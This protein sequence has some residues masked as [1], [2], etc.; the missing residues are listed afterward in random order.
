MLAFI[1][2][3]IIGAVQTVLLS[4]V[5]KGALG[6]KMKDTL[7]ALLL[8]LLTYGIGFTVL[9]F[10]FLDSIFYAAAG[11]IAGVIVSFT[12]VAVKGFEKIK[13]DSINKG[14]DVNGHG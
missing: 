11:L 4:V 14:D 9:Y 1:F 5:L 2:C 3:A 13:S 6:G 8:K 12:V 7:I 10:F